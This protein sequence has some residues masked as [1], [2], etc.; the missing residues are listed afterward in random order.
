M[1]CT[2]QL[3]VK[4]THPGKFHR[5]VSDSSPANSSLLILASFNRVWDLPTA[6]L[7]LHTLAVPT[8]VFGTRQC[9]VNSTHPVQ[10]H[11]C[12]W[13]SSPVN[14]GLLT[15]TNFAV[16]SGTHPL[17][18]DNYTPWKFSQQCWGYANYD[19]K[20]THH[21]RF[22]SCDWGSLPEMVYTPSQVS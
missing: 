15:L 10:F 9:N 22:H 20:P 14:W 2:R 11:S 5:R 13:D 3:R 1:I 6:V 19:V 17:Q 7:S 4:F 8:V 21:C 12:V 18:C 16:V